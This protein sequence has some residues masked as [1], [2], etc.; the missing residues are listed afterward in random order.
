ME[1]TLNKLRSMGDPICNLGA[2][3]Y[4]MRHALTS[5]KRLSRKKLIELVDEAH[6]ALG[7]IQDGKDAVIE[8]MKSEART[9]DMIA[10]EK[11]S[12]GYVAI[13]CQYRGKVIDKLDKWLDTQSEKDFENLV[14]QHNHSKEAEKNM[15]EARKKPQ[16]NV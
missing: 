15:A 13:V 7:R 10:E 4:E 14:A 6:A 1:E 11:L 2:L 5:P 16:T 3:N 12:A 8:D 9:N